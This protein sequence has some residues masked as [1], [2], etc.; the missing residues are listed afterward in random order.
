MWWRNCPA[1]PLG[2]AT[3]LGL[4]FRAKRRRSRPRPM[5]GYRGGPA[6]RSRLSVEAHNNLRWTILQLRRKTSLAAALGPSS[7]RPGPA[8]RPTYAEARYNLGLVLLRARPAG[9]GRGVRRGGGRPCS[10]MR[11]SLMRK[12]A[13]FGLA[14]AQAAERPE[15]RGGGAFHPFHPTSP[16]RFA[17]AHYKLANA[18]ARRWPAGRGRDPVPR[19]RSSSRSRKMARRARR[20]SGQCADAPAPAGARRWPNMRRR[21]ACSPATPA[22]ITISA[23]PWPRL[24]LD[25]KAEAAFQEA[26]RLRPDFPAARAALA[27]LH[28][29]ARE[30][31][32]LAQFPVAAAGHDHTRHGN[33]A[34]QRSPSAG[35]PGGSLTFV[36][37]G[38]A[39]YANSFSAP[40]VF[41]AAP[42]VTRY[43]SIRH[44]WPIWA[45]LRLRRT[46]ARPWRAGPLLNFSLALS[47]AL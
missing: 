14:L 7:P 38:L 20:Q 30:P 12:R 47:Y 22:S 1:N 5:R 3:D 11:P 21:S 9:G 29:A 46:T 4:G 25:A 6:P 10:S 27:H 44:L 24:G 15:R 39:V 35:D 13:H 23:A 31:G 34:P 2:R 41:D 42:I 16:P 18:L 19:R 26:L 36:L 33:P 45:A 8:L 40:F 17:P 32:A 43:P 28:A 37:A